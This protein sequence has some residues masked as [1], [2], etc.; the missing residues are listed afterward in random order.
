MDKT[1]KIKGARGNNLKNVDLEIPRDKMVVFTG[2]SG[3]GKTSL[4]FDTIY[5]EGQRRYV[6]SLSAYARQ[7]LGQMEKPD[8]DFIEG[9]SPAISIDQ[10]TTSQNPRSTVGTVTEIYD[11]L[12]LLYARVG[13]PHCPVCG[14][15][16][17]KQTV[18]QIV[19]QILLMPEKTRLQVLAPVVVARKGE[20]TKLLDDARKNGYVRARIDGDVLDLSEGI[21]LDKK[22]K[23]TIEIVIDR[24]VV[25]EGIQKRLSE[26]IEAAM[27]LTG[28]LLVVNAGE[29]DTTYS[30]HFACADCG[31]SLPEPEPRM[32]SF[33][34][35]SGAC[36]DCAGLG[37]KLIFDP[38]LVVPNPMLTL[39]QGA[40][41]APGWGS[42]KTGHS[43]GYSL[44]EGLSREYKF[45]LDIPYEELSEKIKNM[46]MY[47]LS[48]MKQISVTFTGQDGNTRTYPYKFEGI[49][50]NLWRRYNE[51]SSMAS[52]QDYE[53]FMTSITCPACA[54][55]R[56]KPEILAVT[57]GDEPI[58]AVTEMTIS[59]VQDFFSAIAPSFSPAESIIAVPILKEIEART[60]FLMDV[61]LDYLT[62][63]RA[64]GSLSGG[65]AQRI[66]LATQIGSG[67]VGVVYILD[68]PSIGLHQRD[69]DRLLKTLR[70]LTDIGNTL[71]VVEH[72][73]DTM[74]ASDFIVDI[75]PGAGVH[76]GEVVFAGDVKELLHCKK[77]ITG[78][79][80]NGTLK[81][82]IPET[83]RVSNKKRSRKIRILGAA[84][85]NLRNIDVELPIGLF[86]CVT[87]VSGSG[88]SSL[89]NE[90]LYKRLARD[91]N[92]ARIKPG[93]HRDI[94]GLEFLDKI[95]NIDQSPIGRTPRSNPA[96]Y[97]G[98]FDLVRDVFSQTPEAKIRG[99]QKGRFSFNVKGGRC[100][101]CSGD[102]IIKIEMHF[103]PDVYV[104]C[105]VCGG[106]RYN[107]ETLEVKYKGK[108]IADVLDM[109]I[110][111]ALE[112][113]ENLPRL[114]DK[115]QTL[116]DV[117]LTYIKLGQSS[118]TLSGGE[119]QRVKL[120]TELSKRQTGKTMYVLDEPTTGL[121]SADVHK[122]I[123]ILQQLTDS[124][125][126][127]V[128]IEHNL[129][130]IKTSDYVID[131][132]PEGGG[133]GGQIVVC[134]TPEDVA[135]CE[136]SFTGKFLKGVLGG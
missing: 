87:G 66:R 16:V 74:M 95:I 92:R 122:L 30:Q 64:A 76:G 47:G 94:M 114:K 133:A 12:R 53:G 62:L 117:G 97:T 51:T 101:A 41:A 84:E 89:I 45:K 126:T 7:F 110:E 134:G 105:E 129:D 118:T 34:N 69:N 99:Y 40:I 100:E 93:K 98:L 119:A 46:L 77:S 24:L 33:N 38:E 37:M 20:H 107:R 9:L 82:E 56:L 25:R 48:D 44:L 67:L 125:N 60:G 136:G 127:V 85:N 29:D 39:A 112:F 65:E 26:S 22:K 4:A 102:G 15:V 32:F 27:A 35:P 31:V 104:P 91:L 3:S 50:N 71:I 23:H 55:K 113:F 96:T 88:K 63:S 128:V 106:K 13:I 42:V 57:V 86:T 54:G 111:S 80:L 75:G 11:Y 28:G 5:A 1:I 49:V 108:T 19:D 121:H 10:K 132:G 83:R 131:L 124:G 123:G 59:G 52:K 18:D 17:E 116:C 8:V 90:I 135:A 21:K 109:T 43:W 58:S 115:L 6:E 14:K 78:Q 73:T 70:H 103:L 61:G 72:D 36:V 68:E 81:I 79:Y 2:L 130:V 120:A